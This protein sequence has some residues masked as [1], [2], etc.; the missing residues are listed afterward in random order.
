MWGEAGG[1]RGGD[2]GES[3]ESWSRSMRTVS[4]CYSTVAAEY[5]DILDSVVDDGAALEETA[6]LEATEKAEKAVE[7]EFHELV[8]TRLEG[9]D[10][11]TVEQYLVGL[12]R[13]NK[14]QFVQTMSFKHHQVLSTD[15]R[16]STILQ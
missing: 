5:K 12:R 13:R 15:C 6:R 14:A 11:R 9:T 3:H 16:R 4:L 2:R 1:R 10:R 7:S 8:T